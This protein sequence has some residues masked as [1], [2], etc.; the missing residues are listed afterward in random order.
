MTFNVFGGMLNF[1][2]LQLHHTVLY[3]IDCIV[4]CRI[5]Q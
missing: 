4:A 2:Q 1:T 3:S 5:F